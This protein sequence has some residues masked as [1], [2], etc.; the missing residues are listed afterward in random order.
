MLTDATILVNADDAG[1]PHHAPSAAP[2]KSS[3]RVVFE[4]EHFVADGRKLPPHHDVSR[5]Y[6][7]PLSPNDAWEVVQQ[8]L[9]AP[10]GLPPAESGRRADH[11]TL[12]ELLI[13]HDIRGNTV[14]DAQLAALAV[15]H[16]VPLASLDADFARLPELH[17]IN[18]LR[19]P[20]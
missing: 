10:V 6:L 7:L 11:R 1:S 8:W 9:D 3:I 13:S 4:V 18:Q 12:G 5:P 17:L 16:S 20:H 2:L 19:E 14:N 15:E